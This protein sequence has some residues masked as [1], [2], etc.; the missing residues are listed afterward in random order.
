MLNRKQAPAFSSAPPVKLKPVERFFLKNGTPV[1]LLPSSSLEVFKLE[2]VFDAGSVFGARYGQSFFT[3]RLLMGG[4]KNRS[5]HE[6]QEYFDR[7]G[8]FIEVSQNQERLYVVLHGLSTHFSKYLAPITALLYES[9]FPVEE[10]NTQKN[11]SLQ[12]YKVNKEKT[13]YQAGQ[14][15]RKVIFGA[16]HFFG[17]SLDEQEIKSIER[18]DLTDFYEQRILNRPCNLFLSGNFSDQNLKDLDLAFSAPVNKTTGIPS[19]VKELEPYQVSHRTILK[20]EALQSSIRLGRRLFNRS[21]PDFYRFLVMNTVLGGYFGSR[22]MK[23]I[24]EEKGF[25]Y[26]I[27][28]SLVPLAFTGYFVISTDVKAENTEETIEEI[29]KEIRTLCEV[30]VPEEELLLVRNYM[31]GSLLGGL[32]TPFE[33]MD[34]HKAILFEQLDKDFYHDFIPHIQAVTAAD[35]RETAIKYLG[36]G[37]LSEM[38]A[39]KR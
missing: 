28:S 17:K 5:S 24:R 12:S 6:L 33:M 14:E 2:F 21:H 4:T 35:V 39:G 10:L 26:G 20:N 9:V 19:A 11:I 18:S 23:N 22:L 31:A 29:Y 25:T 3:S 8:G 36:D 32:N 27:S 16:D 37:Q 34:K 15:I 1:F 30:P 13:A 38:V 7:F